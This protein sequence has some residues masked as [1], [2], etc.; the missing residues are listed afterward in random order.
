MSEAKRKDNQLTKSKRGMYFNKIVLGLL[1][2]VIIFNVVI[3]VLLYKRK[4]THENADPGNA[5]MGDQEA[6]VA[7]KFIELPEFYLSKGGAQ[8]PDLKGE[9]L[10]L[11]DLGSS[12]VSM[13]VYGD[14]IV[15]V[16]VEDAIEMPVPG[17]E[18][19][20]IRFYTKLHAVDAVTGSSLWVSGD[21]GIDRIRY[22][23]ILFSGSRVYVVAGTKDIGVLVLGFNVGGSG[24]RLWSQDYFIEGSQ[25]VGAALSGDI[26]AVSDI[27]RTGEYELH[28]V[29]T[30]TGRLKW[31]LFLPGRTSTPSSFNGYL[32]YIGKDA[33]DASKPMF[34]SDAWVEVLNGPAGLTVFRK[35]LGFSDIWGPPV[36]IGSKIITAGQWAAGRILVECY[37]INDPEG[38]PLWQWDAW[39]AG[40][41]PPPA[42]IVV[43]GGK[44][45][46]AG[47]GGKP[48]ML[49]IEDGSSFASEFPEGDSIIFP[50]VSNGNQVYFVTGDGVVALSVEDGSIAWNFSFPGGYQP[51][52][53]SNL[54]YGDGRLYC[55]GRSGLLLAIE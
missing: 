14:G 46:I 48:V 28:A 53:S 54:A 26:I 38:P 15:Y 39:L 6:D 42:G 37:D 2:A 22:S 3:V 7:K 33:F 18:S 36:L 40:E 19:G 21:F 20:Y 9:A 8:G 41:E 43:V 51:R 30:F 11:K 44:C 13:P 29:G 5:I 47:P 1:I 55:P 50:P 45:I 12:I 23:E 52:A 31:H 17:S 25:P 27:S 24:E 4:A 34:I 35:E 49:S 10:W 16:V 32:S